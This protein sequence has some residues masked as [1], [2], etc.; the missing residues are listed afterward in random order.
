MQNIQ[1]IEFNPIN[2]FEDLKSLIAGHQAFV[3]IL[4]PSILISVIQNFDLREYL[5]YFYKNPFYKIIYIAYLDSEVAGY[6]SNYCTNCKLIS[7]YRQHSYAILNELFV[8]E[9]FRKNGIATKLI[10][11]SIAWAKAQDCEYMQVGYA[12][13]N[14]N[15]ER[16]YNRRSGFNLEGQLSRIKL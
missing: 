3:R 16:L 4:E 5:N 15:A 9:Q 11:S 10:K 6:I 14:K 7:V 1:I 2:H 13:H 8:F 12:A